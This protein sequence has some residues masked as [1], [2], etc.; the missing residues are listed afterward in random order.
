MRQTGL[1]LLAST[2][3]AAGAQAAPL[4]FEVSIDTSSLTAGSTAF[5]DVSFGAG[6]DT[7]DA[8]ALT[9]QGFTTDA[10]LGAP[11][12]PFGTVNGNLPGNTT[13]ENLPVPG[14][15]YSQ[16]LFL[17]SYVS[18]KL[19]LNGPLVDTPSGGLDGSSFAVFLY[20]G[21]L[22][23]LLSSDALFIVDVDGVGEVNVTDLSESVRISDP[24]AVPEPS[25]Y[26]LLGGGLAGLALLTRK[27]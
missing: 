25:G 9:I 15:Y 13:L 14:S 19:L 12:V 16:E 27:R 7:A 20:D 4:L 1:L 5:L 2:L 24:V 10:T 21:N 17:G 3:L 26:A 8:G 6:S 11:L 18:F 22:T 23:P